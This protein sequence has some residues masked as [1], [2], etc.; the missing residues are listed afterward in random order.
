MNI[1]FFGDSYVD[2][3]WKFDDTPREWKPWSR[4]LIEDNNWKAV[5]SGVSGS[6]QYHAINKWNKFIQ[7]D[8]NNIDMAIWTFTWENRIYHDNE[9]NQE[10]FF[11]VAEKRKIENLK[12]ELKIDD[13]E[14]ATKLYFDHIY[15]DEF[16]CYIH[17]LLIEKILNLPKLYPNIK[18]IFI[19]N[20]ELSKHI[21]LKHFSKGVLLDFAFETLS[22]KETNSPGIMPLTCGRVGH[23]NDKNAEIFK[24]EIEQ[25]IG[26]YDKIVD[27]V[28]NIDYNKFDIQN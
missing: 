19:P 15:S 16:C 20:T 10:V 9:T 8:S 23:I 21:A 1:G 25:V 3:H 14:L 13:I 17:E 18:F 24:S 26:S 11:S 6:S 2:L 27:S 5:N 12:N 22:N 4:R 7:S 28:I